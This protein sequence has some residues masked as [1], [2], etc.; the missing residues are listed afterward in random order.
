MLL[1]ALKLKYKYRKSPRKRSVAVAGWH[2]LELV[3]HQLGVSNF[4]IERAQA[5]LEMPARDRSRDRSVRYS[6]R[7]IW[8]TTKQTTSVSHAKRLWPFGECARAPKRN[9]A[10]QIQALICISDRMDGCGI[11]GTAK[12]A[13]PME[14]MHVGFFMNLLGFCCST[15]RK[16]MYM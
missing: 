6:I 10:H 2:M 7:H 14:I 8:F 15:N 5:T 1:S 11:A 12:N 4:C 3:L 16:K 9:C 13:R